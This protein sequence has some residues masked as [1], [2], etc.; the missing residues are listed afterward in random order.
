M[1]EIEVERAFDRL[2]TSAPLTGHKYRHYK[3][4]EYRITGSSVK[5]DTLEVL[6]TYE[7][8]EPN[9]LGPWTRTL[10]DFLAWVPIKPGLKVGRFTFVEGSRTP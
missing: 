6:V 10:D 2:A 9:K 4:G 8:C 5:E 7:P 3:G 1:I